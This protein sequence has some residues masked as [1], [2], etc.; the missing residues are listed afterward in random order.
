MQKRET[1]SSSSSSNWQENLD[2]EKRNSLIQKL[3][4]WGGVAVVT[5]AAVFFLVKMSGGTSTQPTTFNNLP[6]VSSDEIFEGN[7]EAKLTVV[8]YSDFQC[9]ACAAYN[10]IVNQLLSNYQGKVNFVYRFFPLT[11]VHQNALVSAQAGYAAW[12]MGKFMEMK[13][14]LFTNQAEWENLSNDDAKKKFVEYAKSI[15]LNGDEFEKIMNSSE[16]NDAVLKAE[17]AALALGLE[18]TPSFF[19]GNNQ[20]KPN[21]YEDFKQII[22]DQLNGGKPLK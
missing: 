13:D 1:E 4:I 19:I 8:E 5:I 6:K 14:E 18:G 2:K 3:V 7:K 9:P 16:A 10:P 11:S 20:I 12:K 22:D 21:G 15:K 17:K